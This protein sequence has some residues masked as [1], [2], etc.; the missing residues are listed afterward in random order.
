MR[1]V[2]TGSTWSSMWPRQRMFGVSA[3][4]TLTIPTNAAASA[5]SRGSQRERGEG[6]KLLWTW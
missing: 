1:I 3:E 6:V 5:A 4:P 2:W